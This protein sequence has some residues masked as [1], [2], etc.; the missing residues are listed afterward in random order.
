MERSAVKPVA[1]FYAL[2]LAFFIIV[3]NSSP[4]AVMV[5]D[6]FTTV[7]DSF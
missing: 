6:I 5:K 7:K 1:F 2:F 3:V 4:K